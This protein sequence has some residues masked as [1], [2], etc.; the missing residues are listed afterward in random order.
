MKN[1]LLL[2]IEAWK[3]DHS[4]IALATVVSAIE[5]LLAKKGQDISKTLAEN[6]ATLLEPDSIS[7]PNAVK[8]FRDI[9]DARSRVMHGDD[10][11]TKDDLLYQAKLLLAGVMKA[12]IQRATF[13]RRMGHSMENP[14]ALLKEL[15]DKK[16]GPGQPAGVSVSEIRHLWGGSDQP[17]SEGA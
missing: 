10:I 13:M 5:A 4:G 12:L 6:V 9:Y 15:G 8:F 14:D 16:F 17:K 1:A 3:L 11:S 2:A 7:R